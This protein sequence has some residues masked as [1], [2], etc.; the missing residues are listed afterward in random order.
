MSDTVEYGPRFDEVRWSVP[1]FWRRVA[2]ECPW[3]FQ[4][5]DLV[6]VTR[7]GE[8]M[9]VA[10]VHRRL[11]MVRGIDS[12]ACPLRKGDEVLVVGNL[13]SAA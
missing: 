1:S 3:R 12:T 6:L 10:R 7:T 9:R 8:M 4:R 5:D 11:D 2:V 13:R